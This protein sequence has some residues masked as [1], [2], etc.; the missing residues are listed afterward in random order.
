MEKDIDSYY[1]CNECKSEFSEPPGIKKC[2]FCNSTSLIEAEN[3]P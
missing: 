1:I 3:A 2:L